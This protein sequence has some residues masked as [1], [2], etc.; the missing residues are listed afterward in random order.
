MYLKYKETLGTG[1]RIT[2]EI[3]E[4]MHG[5]ESCT[6]GTD[7]V[8][9]PKNVKVANMGMNINSSYA[10]Y[11][12]VLASD[13]KTLM[14][15]S[16]RYG[17]PGHIKNNKGF[18]DSDIYLSKMEGGAWIEAVKLDGEI[19]TLGNEGVV[20]M[21]DEEQTLIVFK[22]E[23]NDGNLYLSTIINGVWKTPVYWGVGI[24]SVAEESS[25]CL[26]AD[27]RIL[28]FVSDRDGGMGG[29]DIYKCLRLPNGKWGPPQNLGPIVNTKYDEDAIFVSPNGRE[30]FFSSKGHKTMGGYDVFSSVIDSENG[31]LSPPLNVGYPINT[32]GDDLYYKNVDNTIA[33]IASDRANGMGGLDI[34]QIKTEE[35]EQRDITLIVGRII[36]NSK[37]DLSDNLILVIDRNTHEIIQEL[38]AN[39]ATGKFGI[40]LP[41]GSTYQ[42]QY[43]I[44]GK[45]ILNEVIETKRGGGYQVLVRE[46]PYGV[47]ER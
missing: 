34:Y 46:I 9:N 2:A 41:I 32:T 8:K 24:N 47:C 1:R 23:G 7:L 11:S 22:D 21:A 25:A 12:P 38:E 40:D 4:L 20:N 37:E 28:Y 14:F 33:F 19:N 15:T 45:E 44:K 16:K 18:Y 3:E 10:D 29:K 27:G 36:N 39:N 42:I 6:N 30:I 5:I 17:G 26:S 31:F 35:T 13:A 43:F